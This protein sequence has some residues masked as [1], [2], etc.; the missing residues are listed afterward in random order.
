MNREKN[1]SNRSEQE[2]QR[3]IRAFLNDDMASFDKLVLKYKDLIFNLCY[4]FLNNYEEADD[5]AQDTFV[6]VY[7]GLSSF[8]FESSFSTWVYRIAVN[9]C[10][11][12]TASMKY[13]IDRA[14]IRLDK[15][16]E[17][18]NGVYPMEVEDDTHSPEKLVEKKEQ[19]RIIQRAIDT[20]PHKQKKVIVLRDIEG[21]A[22]EQIVEITGHKLGTVKS[23]LARA[24]EMLRNK[25]EG[26]I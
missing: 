22:Y 7:R 25:L 15:P 24:R 17:F 18:D 21:L 16:K 19:S 11:N 5:C 26:V 10:K 20:L 6:K 8:R 4:R 1:R 2:D 9:T 12:K 13:R 3:L 23:K 14:M